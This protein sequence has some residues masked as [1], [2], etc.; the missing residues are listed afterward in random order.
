MGN[1][2]S[3]GCGSLEASNYPA[4]HRN[5]RNATCLDIDET[6]NMLRSSRDQKL[7]R[8][9]SYNVLADCVANPITYC[10]SQQVIDF[11][12]R[13][14]RIIEEIANSEASLVCL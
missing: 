14:P 13:G 1:S 10:T 9:M 11:E 7:I 8:V 4:P 3:C 12:F 5:L 6:A 2:F